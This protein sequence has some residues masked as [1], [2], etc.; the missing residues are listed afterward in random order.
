MALKPL[1]PR[2]QQVLAW[3]A[4]GCP[5]GVMTD[6][7]YKNSAMALRNR[8]LV[9]ITRRGGWRAELTQQGRDHLDR[10]PSAQDKAETTVPPQ[11]QPARLRKP[12]AV[13]N[14]AITEDFIANARPSDEDPESDPAAH[15]GKPVVPDPEPKKVAV[16]SQLRTLHPA[17][18]VLRDDKDRLGITS[19]ARNRALSILQGL[20]VAAER[21][22]Y[23]VQAVRQTRSAYGYT[24]WDS[25]N[26]LVINTGEIA[27]G[28]RILQESDRSP[29]E[30]TASE[31]DRQK[32]WGSNPPK[33]DHKPNDQLRIE[34]DSRWDGRRHARRD[35][36]RGSLESKLPALL[37]EVA[38]RHFNAAERRKI[39]E[40]E[41]AER[42]RRRQIAIDRAKILLRE[43]HRAQVLSRQVA[44]WREARG[45]REYVVAME[46]VIEAMP[47]SQAKEDAEQW[48]IWSRKH[49]ADV[50]PLARALR[51]PDD[52]EPTYEALRPFL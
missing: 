45:L 25:K 43:S 32:R 50:D 24:T 16:P 35:G 1:N 9:K 48:L 10:G 27:I 11:R 15:L 49:A 51:L 6:S 30:P 29:H 37:D 22:G 3:I 4:D 14:R 44:Q 18:V 33:Y 40:Q 21:E 8:H 39:E 13:E 20:A 19:L 31:L 46:Q 28:V 23:S 38:A 7:T 42:E 26:H 34:I 17:V 41:Q 2:Q 47:E 36:T 52:P 12:P 5:D